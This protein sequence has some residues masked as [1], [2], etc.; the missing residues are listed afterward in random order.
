LESVNQE[1]IPY[2][3]SNTANGEAR[4]PLKMCSQAVEEEIIS[5][6]FAEGNQFIHLRR[7]F[8]KCPK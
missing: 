6:L 5:I 4:K 2:K 1:Q 8:L 3:V 7:L